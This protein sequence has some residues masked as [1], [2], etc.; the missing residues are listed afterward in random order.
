MLGILNYEFESPDGTTINYPIRLFRIIDPQKLPK[1]LRKA[2][3]TGWKPVLDITSRDI[4]SITNVPGSINNDILNE[5]Y[6]EGIEVLKKRGSYIL[7]KAHL[8]QNVCTWS[9]HLQVSFIK[10]YG[11][12]S[13]LENLPTHLSTTAGK[14]H[15]DGCKR[16]KTPINSP[17]VLRRRVATSAFAAASTTT[18]TPDSS[19]VVATAPI[20]VS[21]ATNKSKEE[22]SSGTVA[23]GPKGGNNSDDAR[24]TTA[25]GPTTEDYYEADMAFIDDAVLEAKIK[26]VDKVDI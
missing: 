11:T 25:K 2:F 14:S 16:K 9:K 17:W 23:M 13:D 21:V 18:P 5:L 22:R 12:P 10:K 20:N 1:K 26:H 19:S 15:R 4:V 3:S 7:K 24:F 8:S 6:Q